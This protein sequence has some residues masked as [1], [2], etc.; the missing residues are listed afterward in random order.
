MTAPALA[1]A[2]LL[3]VLAGY[4]DLWR[5]GVSLAAV[6]LVLGYCALLPAAL[7]ASR[8]RGEPVPGRERPPYGIA[9]LVG[10]AVLALY[11][12][13]L[14]PTTAMWDASE[15]IAVAKVLGLPHPPGNPLFV[16][17][18]HVAGLVPIPVSY[19]ARINLLA[20][21]ASAASAAL[22]FLCTERALRS[23][24]AARVPRLAA[25]A[26]GSLLGA[27]AFTVWNQS[28]V[29]EKVYT[30]SLLGL[31]LTSWLVLRWLDAQD[32]VDA[33]TPQ[34]RPS[35]T[36]RGDR[37][38]VVMAW[39][40]GLGYAV[41]PAGFLTG[42]AVAAAVLMRRPSVLLRWRLLLVLGVAVVGALTLF[43]VEPIRSAH[44]PPINEGMP[45]ACEQGRP[46][47][48]CTLSAE[49]G[50]RLMAN[51]RRE[52]YGGHPV[53]ERKAPFGAQLG[54]WWLY[55]EWQWLR[56][57][58]GRAPA[59]Q[60][61]LAMAFLVL[62]VLGLV[63]LRRRERAAWW[64]LAPLAGTLT[65][66]LVFY[67]N[68]NYGYSQAPSLGDTVPR[69]VRDRDYFFVWTY[70][71]WGMFAALGLAA[72][73]RALADGLMA[74]GA[75]AR[76]AWAMA[77]PV[78]A[79][80]LVPAFGNATAASR[81]GQTFTREWAVDLLNSVEP[82][83]V[84]VTNGD[85]DSFPLWYAQQVEG[86]RRDVTVALVPYLGLPWYARQLLVQPPAAYDPARGPAL[87]AA[88]RTP[89]PT[90]PLWD[91]TPRGT[92]AIPD[93]VQLA[94]PQ[95]FQHGEMDVTVPAGVL[96]RDQLLVLRAIKDSFPE[97][98]V[99]FTN[100]GY[101]AALGFGAYVRQQGLAYRLEPRPLVASATLVPVSGV[102]VDVP[103]SVALWSSTYRGTTALLREGQWVDRASANIPA[104]YA[105]TG[106]Q[107]AT[108][109]AAS[110]DTGAAMRVARQV[111]AMARSARL[112]PAGE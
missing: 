95:R 98:P 70:S 104:N 58:D 106:Q 48:D 13:T 33:A 12:A 92:D 30:V 90:Q 53:M 37:L 101:P 31:A 5:G 56:D 91:L 51:I 25:A 69:E 18:A 7:W 23:P 27:T 107:L 74:R 60:R 93:Y 102:H 26:A 14:A 65:L 20:A 110:G 75:P 52:Q 55:F 63:A 76:R 39:V 47:V 50:R 82:Y 73:W 83:G 54:M 72:L 38:L 1:A 57:P 64:Y 15:Y 9:A 68:F 16:L 89:R 111:E 21:A 3:A 10:L 45:T 100:P 32:A 81:A 41:H 85:N 79:L 11:V 66:A 109:L 22:W 78:L 108:A 67:L 62:A 19:A 97:R 105:L 28:V 59:A 99:Y 34:A 103:R 29:N 35:A 49:T 44:L 42:P 87:Y 94:E 77:A 36:S 17:L 96:T 4:V 112:L 71:A 2:G 24:L 86:V 80:A 84:L 61:T 8:A 46:R 43:A 6:L 40:A 88:M